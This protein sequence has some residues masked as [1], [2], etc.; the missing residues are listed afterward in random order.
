VDV[1]DD[2]LQNRISIDWENV[3]AE[4]G[5]KTKSR[6]LPWLDWVPY[7]GAR[8]VDFIC[9]RFGCQVTWKV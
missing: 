7:S 1:I 3:K 9:V 6:Q 4:V 2:E 5:S 8:L